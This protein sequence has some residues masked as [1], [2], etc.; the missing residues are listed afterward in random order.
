MFNM[1]RNV[2]EIEGVRVV[3]QIKYLVRSESVWENESV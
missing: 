1:E 3:E 2:E